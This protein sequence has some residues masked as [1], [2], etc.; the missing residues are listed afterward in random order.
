MN[1]YDYGSGYQKSVIY[2]IKTGKEIGFYDCLAPNKY[3]EFIIY[4]FN[5]AIT[6]NKSALHDISINPRYEN[7]LR[8]NITLFPTMYFDTETKV[9]AFNFGSH[10]PGFYSGSSLILGLN[11]VKKYLNPD[12]VFFKIQDLIK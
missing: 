9:L 1:P 8:F 4:L 6:E 11:H 5:R 7:M 3:N 10:T 2:N 12:C